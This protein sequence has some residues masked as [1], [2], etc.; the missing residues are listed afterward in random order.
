MDSLLLFN[1]SA[2]HPN[3][4][5]TPCKTKTGLVHR[6]IL[7]KKGVQCRPDLKL[8]TAIK[9]FTYSFFDGKVISGNALQGG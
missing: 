9:R 8:D 2:V 4:I 3:K 7:H 6:G 1:Q 5:N